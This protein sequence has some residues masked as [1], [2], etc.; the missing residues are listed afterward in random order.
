MARKRYASEMEETKIDMT[1][2]LDIVFIMLIFFIVTTSFVKPTGVAYDSPESSSQPNSKKGE[3]ILITVNKTGIIKIANRQ[4]DIERL[5]ANIEQMR[6]EAPE[7]SVLILAD[8]ET[9]HGLV[10]KVMDQ[11]KTAGV[12]KVS[13]AQ[14]RE[15]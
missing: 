4:V 13:V 14:S 5:T 6:A 15:Q 7:A 1:P 3:N 11:A 12:E 9:R 2:L 10:V 8:K